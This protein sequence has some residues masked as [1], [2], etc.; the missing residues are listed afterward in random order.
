M[1]QV[2]RFY[3]EIKD[4]DTLLFYAIFFRSVFDFIPYEVFN[5]EK[6]ITDVIHISGQHMLTRGGKCINT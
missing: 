5:S 3:S 6:P 4:R 2:Q 1:K